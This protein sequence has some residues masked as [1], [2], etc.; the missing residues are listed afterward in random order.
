LPLAALRFIERGYAGPVASMALPLFVDANLIIGS[1]L[2]GTIAL[3]LKGKL[4]PTQAI[5]VRWKDAPSR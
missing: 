1:I 5:V 3:L 4:L 2:V